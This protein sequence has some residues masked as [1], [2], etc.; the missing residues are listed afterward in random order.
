MNNEQAKFILRAYRPGGRDAGDAAFC[1]ALRQAQADPALGAWFAQEQA[2]DT[3]V[4]AKL[5]TAAPPP[6]LREAILTGAGLSAPAVPPRRRL[7][8]WLALAASVAVVAGAAATYWLVGVRPPRL[9]QVTELA[10]SEPF[11][12]H[13][14]PHA[15]KLGTLGAWLENPNSRMTAMP[16]VSLAQ[17]K[18][19]GCRSVSV[20]GHE[21]FEI[22]FR[23]G[24]WYHLYIA[25]RSDFAASSDEGTPVLLAQGERSA[26]TWAGDRLVYVLMTKGGT[27]ALEQIL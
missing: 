17:L 19:E 4:A 22:C 3:A 24:A 11:S 2:F 27:E 7:P 6:G 16:A 13:T 1:E 15:D 20:A 25:R 21:V 5:R 18:A 12:A 10:L 9:E 8:A 14:G 26:A 23:H